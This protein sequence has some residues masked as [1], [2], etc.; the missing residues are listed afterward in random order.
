MRRETLKVVFAVSFGCILSIPLTLLTAEKFGLL[1]LWTILMGV[2]FMVIGT[3]MYDPKDTWKVV[4]TTWI[5]TCMWRPDAIWWKLLK[6]NCQGQGA[7]TLALGGWVFAITMS[8]F[9]FVMVELIPISI[10]LAF[11]IVSM[12]LVAAL[13][14]YLIG[15]I[16]V[17]CTEMMSSPLLNISTIEKAEENRN[18]SYERARKIYYSLI[19]SPVISLIWIFTTIVRMPNWW[20]YS[21]KPFI[22]K[23]FTRLATAGRKVTFWCTGVGFATGVSYGLIAHVGYVAPTLLGTITGVAIA[24]LLVEIIPIR[25]LKLQ[26]Q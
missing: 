3:I 25:I 19:M 8:I 6:I 2:V 5:E 12:V 20:Y 15:T 10:N 18:L 26:V 4:K 24:F 11:G 16:L 21:G 23:I 13:G 1:L 14:G 9:G 7:I 22:C 17:I